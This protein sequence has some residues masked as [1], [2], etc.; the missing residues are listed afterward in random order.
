MDTQFNWF[1]NQ[2]TEEVYKNGLEASPQAVIFY[3]FGEVSKKLES[4]VL[5]LDGKLMASAISALS[6]LLGGVAGKVLG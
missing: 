3:C 4:R 6:L 5:R 2:A 1:V